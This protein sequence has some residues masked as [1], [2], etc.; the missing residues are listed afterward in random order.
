MA[1]IT[2]ETRSVSI[3]SF[4]REA[5]LPRLEKPFT[6]EQLPA[7]VARPEED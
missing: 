2:G 5:G 4:L 3:A 6:P 7:L 1:F